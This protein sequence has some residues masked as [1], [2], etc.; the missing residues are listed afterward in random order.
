MAEAFQACRA[1]SQS[2]SAASNG[3]R[4]SQE[5][6]DACS[7]LRRAIRRRHSAVDEGRGGHVIARHIETHPTEVVVNPINPVEPVDT[8]PIVEPV[9]QERIIMD[10]Q[11]VEE[12]VREIM[13]RGEY[14]PGDVDNGRGHGNGHRHR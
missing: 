5:A 1:A 9:G 2:I 11:R 4:G 10:Q 14:I 8:I 6:A 12:I 13:R 7:S 3:G